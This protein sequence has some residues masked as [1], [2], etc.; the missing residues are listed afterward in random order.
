MLIHEL[1]NFS[2]VECPDLD[3]KCL[4]EGLCKGTLLQEVGISILGKTDFRLHS[5]K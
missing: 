4:V 3:N 5:K 1:F 2:Q